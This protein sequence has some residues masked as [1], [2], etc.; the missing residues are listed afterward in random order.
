MKEIL[1]A[2]ASDRAL[3]WPNLILAFL[4]G[5]HLLCEFFH[6]IHSFWARRKD[7]QKAD[8]ILTRIEGIEKRMEENG[9]NCPLKKKES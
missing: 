3:T 6:Y 5:V 2:I 1:D 8:N 9:R 7:S 4:I